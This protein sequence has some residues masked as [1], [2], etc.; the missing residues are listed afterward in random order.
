[1]PIHIELW[2]H[3]MIWEAG[4]QIKVSVAGHNLRPE[5][6]SEVGLPQTLNRGKIAIYTGGRYDSHLL[7][8]FIP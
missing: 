8:P 4:E 5:I 2:P 7:V 3:G 6:R 1:V